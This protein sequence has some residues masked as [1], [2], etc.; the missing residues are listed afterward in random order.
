MRKPFDGNNCLAASI[1]ALMT[2][3]LVRAGFSDEP[4]TGDKTS[5]LPT[6]SYRVVPG[7]Y[8]SEVAASGG[9]TSTESGVQ[10]GSRKFFNAAGVGSTDRNVDST[11]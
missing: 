1:V 6:R 2:L 3:S 10:E 7:T 9:K 5:D 4:K 8:E 11:P